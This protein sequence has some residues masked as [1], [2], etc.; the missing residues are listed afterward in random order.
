MIKTFDFRMTRGETKILEMSVVDETGA[1]VDLTGGALYLSWR[2]DLKSA[3]V[4]ELDSVTGL[5]PAIVMRD[6]TSSATKGKFRATH[7]PA[8]THDLPLGSYVWDAWYVTALGER[9]AV[10][11]PSSV[12][13]LQEVTTIPL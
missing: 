11:S 7:T 1:A 5:T 3:P 4:V 8:V 2:P 13:L 9:Y 12:T 10:V 6:Q